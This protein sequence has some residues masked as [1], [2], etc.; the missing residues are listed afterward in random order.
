MGA[1]LSPQLVDKEGGLPLRHTS[2]SERGEPQQQLL[3]CCIL[4]N[5]SHT[6]KQTET[7]AVYSERQVVALHSK[8]GTKF[9]VLQDNTLYGKPVLK[10]ST[11]ETPCFGAPSKHALSLVH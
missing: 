6:V 1:R 9:L 10:G 2:A 8:Q 4:F 11:C 5:L 7:F 3:Y